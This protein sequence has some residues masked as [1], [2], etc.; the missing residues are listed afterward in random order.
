MFLSW[1]NI[2]TNTKN[3][4]LALFL[5]FTNTC[6]TEKTSQKQMIVTGLAPIASLIKIIAGDGYDVRFIIPNNTDPHYFNLKPSDAMIL[7]KANT[8]IALDD[9]FDGKI[10]STADN[11]KKIYLLNEKS[12]N[13]NNEHDGHDHSGHDHASNP[14]LWISYEH[15]EDLSQKITEILIAEFPE[16][17][18]FFQKNNEL[19]VKNLQE[20]YQQTKQLYKNSN[21][22]VFVVQRHRV[23]D[24]LLE[25]LGVNLIATV[26]EY[27]GEQVSVKKMVAIIDK[28]K[29]V[30]NKNQIILIEDAFTEPSTVLKAISKETGVH[31]KTFNPMGIPESE[32]DNP[33]DFLNFYS[34][35]LIK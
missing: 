28:I 17:R 8:I 11:A 5:L 15:L 3:I 32:N 20:S 19:F 22:Q 21:K 29:Q 18:V 26:Y 23:W 27:E 10:L 1:R 34:E 30:P 31:I 33:I 4:L 16:N 2:L 9:H 14:H 24:Y 13:S 12:D 35:I 7:A 6:G 25:E